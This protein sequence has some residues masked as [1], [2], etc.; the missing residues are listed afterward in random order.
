[1]LRV[2]PTQYERLE[3]AIDRLNAGLE[4]LQTFV[5]PGGGIAAAWL[6]LARAV[7]RRAERSVVSLS[8]T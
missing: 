1:M 5:L 7:C 8:P 6:H 3:Q 2:V 4:P